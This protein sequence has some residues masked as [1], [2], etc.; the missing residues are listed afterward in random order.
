MPAT[1]IAAAR[2]EAVVDATLDRVN[3]A[4]RPPTAT[5]ALPLTRYEHVVNA[6]RE[7]GPMTRQQLADRL[8]WAEPQ[9]RHG[10]DRARKLSLAARVGKNRKM[11]FV[12][13]AVQT[14]GWPVPR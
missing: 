7:D 2:S 11:Q 13:G 14:D 6:L 9:V 3:P 4:W 8:R 1:A 5:A 12:Y 10:L